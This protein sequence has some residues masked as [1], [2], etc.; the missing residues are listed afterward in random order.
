MRLLVLYQARDAAQDHPGY[1]SGFEQLV[2]EGLL[3]AHTAIPYYGVAEARGWDALWSEA[4]QT[5]HRMEADAIFLHFFHGPADPAN[6][7]RRFRSLPGRPT[8]FASLGD[9]YGRWTKR[10]PRHFRTAS[11]LSDVTFLT[12]MGYQARQLAQG[13]SRNLV[14]MPNGCCQVR[15]SA[16]DTCDRARDFDLVFIGSRTPSRNFANHVFW[17][18]RKRAAMVSAFTKRYGQRFALFGKDWDGNPSWQGPLPYEQQHG[19]YRRGAVAVGGL[20]GAYHD[21][22][23]SDRVL[24]ALASGIPFVDFWVRGVDRIWKPQRDWWL[25]SDTEGMMRCCD[26]LLEMPESERRALARQT[27]ERILGSHTQY[28]RCREMVQIVKTLREHRQ[29]GQRAEA[30]T[31]SFLSPALGPDTAPAIVNWQG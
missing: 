17:V 9:G 5:A 10:M 31:L 8:V 29:R 11:T 2:A 20:P 14:L 13:G 21:Y 24:V 27:R 12:G 1:Y 4:Y 3:R 18:G 6:A 25:A 26:R 16:T 19:A 23:T 7:I 15:F 30:P 22:Y 28:H